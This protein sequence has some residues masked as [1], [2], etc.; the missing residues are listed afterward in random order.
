LKDSQHT[1][2]F[3]PSPGQ[4]GVVSVGNT[5]LTVNPSGIVVTGIASATGFAGTLEVV[6]QYLKIQQQ[7]HIVRITQ[8]GTGNALLVEDSSKS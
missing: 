2:W 3:S 7:D 1:G 5:I 4:F 6:L 8:A